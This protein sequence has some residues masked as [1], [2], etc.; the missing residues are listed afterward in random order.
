MSVREYIGARY[1]PIFL[2][3]WDNTV[4][5]EPLSVVQ[6]LG[7]SYTSR[8]YVPAGTALTNNDFWAETGNFNAQVESYRQEE[9][10]F[11]VRIDALEDKFPI[12]STI[13]A[14]GAILGKVKENTVFKT[15]EMYGAIGNGSYDDSAAFQD[16]FD[17]LETGDIVILCQ[18]NYVL[19]H[20]VKC[21]KDYISIVG[22]G[23]TEGT[24]NLR[25][26]RDS[27][28][29]GN[30]KYGLI[31]RGKQNSLTNIVLTNYANEYVYND[32]YLLFLDGSFSETDYQLDT[33]I[34]NCAFGR[35]SNHIA[36]SGRNVKITNCK[37]S[38]WDNNSIELQN[39]AISRMVGY[40]I[41][42][43]RFHGGGFEPV[44]CVDTRKVTTYTS[45][46]SLTMQ[47]NFIDVVGMI[48]RG[49]TDNV[50][51][52]NNTYYQH[53]HGYD[54]VI[55]FTHT[56]IASTG[57]VTSVIGNVFSNKSPGTAIRGFL[58]T[59]SDECAGIFYISDNVFTSA[60]ASAHAI[61]VIRGG[62]TDPCYV[63]ISNNSLNGGNTAT[64]VQI[65]TNS[66]NLQ[67]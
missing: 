14:N 26:I 51:I 11:D 29:T 48:Y 65:V 41:E 3:E 7:N 60:Y 52:A 32:T 35:A 34:V 63:V 44:C 21:E 64:P 1:V 8:Q 23:C 36:I 46:F 43:N 42:N 4:N 57:N 53:V 38:A 27:E 56:V 54:Y 5:Y 16:M 33:K 50:T 37:F 20:A 39:P 40:I 28:P 66:A 2:G 62:N 61:I 22:M 9:L 59:Y 45:I 18:K 25:I 47:N 13:I 49:I 10:A 12:T 6:N 30:D 67:V 55:D 31:I 19:R 58:R 24:P 17:D 15:P